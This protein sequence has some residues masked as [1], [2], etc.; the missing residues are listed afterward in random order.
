[1]QLTVPGS[2]SVTISSQSDADNLSACDTLRG[3]VIFSST[4]TGTITLS[5]VEQIN[6]AIT[7]EGASGLTELIAPDLDTLKGALTLDG[8]DS[9]TTLTMSGLSRVSSGITITSN[10][11]LESLDFGQLE[12]V[13]GQLL[14]TGSFKRSVQSLIEKFRAGLTNDSV[15]LQSLDQVKGQTIIRGGKS[16][17]CGTLN[18]L[19]SDGVF[20]GGYSCS[21][22]ASGNA[23]SAGEKGGIAVGVIVGVLLLLLLLWY[24][25]RQR[26]QRKNGRGRADSSPS[27]EVL[28]NEKSPSTQYKSVPLDDPHPSSP[29]SSPS[30][31]SPPVPAK[32]TVHRKPIGPPPALLDGRSIHEAPYAV[33]PVQEYH[34]LDAGPVF[35]THQRPINCEG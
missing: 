34:E 23:L 16:M 26:R 7:A 24:M 19:Q 6:G 32:S 13:D 29:P 8:L 17:S 33:T 21:A 15:S 18:S 20:Q 5:N 10:S 4:V 35:S 9:L 25:L 1:L 12:E 30:S 14:L 3:S 2:S 27:S 22:G 31:P 28:P 11:Q